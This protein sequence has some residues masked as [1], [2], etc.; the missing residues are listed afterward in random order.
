DEHFPSIHRSNTVYKKEELESL[1]K[2]FNKEKY[3]EYLHILYNNC[4]D[5]LLNKKKR[6]QH[7]YS[8]KNTS[9]FI[10]DNDTIINSNVIDVIIRLSH[11]TDI[12]YVQRL[13][14]DIHLLLVNNRQNSVI[15]YKDNEF[16]I[17]LID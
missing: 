2:Y 6:E 10:D 1:E 16:Y 14:Q 9:L 17:W 11:N 8:I 12:V 15:L 5:W 4:F 3:N 7:R 13:M